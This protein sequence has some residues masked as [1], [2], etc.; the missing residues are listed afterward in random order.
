MNCIS[1]QSNS[2]IKNTTGISSKRKSDYASKQAFCSAG[3][4]KSEEVKPPE[5]S[6]L[7]LFISH[8][9][10]E[11][12]EQINKAKK[13]PPNA[14]FEELYA[15]GVKNAMLNTPVYKIVPHIPFTPKLNPHTQFLP[16]GYKVVKIT[17]GQLNGFVGAIKIE[18]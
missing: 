13:L 2:F 3:M 10:D 9:S 15:Y 14:R 12:I 1:I 17:G 11:Q 4:E 18:K 16:E 8:I 5:I 7:D 6:N